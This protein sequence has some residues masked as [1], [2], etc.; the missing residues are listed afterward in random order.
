VAG[1]VAVAEEGNL[2]VQDVGTGLC[3]AAVVG[4]SLENEALGV[5]AE[6]TADV[7][8]GTADA[9][10]GAHTGAL[11]CLHNFEPAAVGTEALGIP[12]PAIEVETD[13]RQ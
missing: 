4:T 8:A 11:H 1:E 12:L 9:L 13:G 5:A 10:Q 6:G 3:V 2:D 7:P